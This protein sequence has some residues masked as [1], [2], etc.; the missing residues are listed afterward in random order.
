MIRFD[1]RDPLSWTGFALGLALSLTVIA[2]ATPAP[3]PVTGHNGL[4]CHALTP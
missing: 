4:P 2:L 3:A 1:F